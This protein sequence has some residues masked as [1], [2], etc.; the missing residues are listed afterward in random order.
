MDKKCSKNT[1]GSKFTFV[2]AVGLK[3]FP[4]STTTEKCIYSF[5]SQQIKETPQKKRVKKAG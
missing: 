3:L 5:K 1:P 2:T 4:Q